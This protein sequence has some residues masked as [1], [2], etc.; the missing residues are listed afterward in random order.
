MPIPLPPATNDTLQTEITNFYGQVNAEFNRLTTLL[1]IGSNLVWNNDQGYT[2]QQV[3]ST[4]STCAGS[5]FGLSS[6]LC[7]LLGTITGTTPNPV[8]AGWSVVINPDNTVTLAAPSVS[9]SPLGA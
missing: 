2:P 3:I 7:G 4:M 6:L 1:T 8:P 5:I 9:T